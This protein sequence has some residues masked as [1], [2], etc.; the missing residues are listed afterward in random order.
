MAC[1]SEHANILNNFWKIKKLFRE[2]INSHK[3]LKICALSEIYSKKEMGDKSY[4]R[5]FKLMMLFMILLKWA[6]KSS[7]SYESLFTLSFAF[8]VSSL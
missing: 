1:S 2:I 8:T 4:L 7:S 6:K 3:N 5:L